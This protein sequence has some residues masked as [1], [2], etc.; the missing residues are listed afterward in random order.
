MI[1]RAAE[2]S[3]LS[4]EFVSVTGDT[5]GPALGPPAVLKL[6]ADNAIATCWVDVPKGVTPKGPVGLRVRA[7]HG[8]FFWASNDQPLVRVAVFDPDPAGRPLLLGSATLKE[9]TQPDSHEP[10]F[11]FPATAFRGAPPKLQS[12]LFLTVDI[13]D[14]TLRYPR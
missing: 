9:I 6:P 14:L 13:S 8:R 7:N 4:L 3:E 1:G 12:S 10:R 5:A 2:D 11:S